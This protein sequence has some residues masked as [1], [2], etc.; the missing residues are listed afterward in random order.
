[1]V[2][3]HYPLG[4][5]D[6]VPFPRE[7]GQGVRRGTVRMHNMQKKSRNGLHREEKTFFG[8]YI[9]PEMKALVVMT[10]DRLGI[11]MTDIILNGLRNEATRAGVLVNG[12]IPPDLKE[13]YDFILEMVKMSNGRK[14]K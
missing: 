1:M 9:T 14:S 4:V 2:Y 3:R 8:A 6:Y 12:E 13:R 11:T 7:G 10:A 5:V